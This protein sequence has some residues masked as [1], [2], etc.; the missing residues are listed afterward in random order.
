MSWKKT[1]LI[2]VLIA[3][4]I[5]IGFIVTKVNK[6]SVEVAGNQKENIVKHFVT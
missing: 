6:K 4:I 5:G 3:F 2:I 1:I